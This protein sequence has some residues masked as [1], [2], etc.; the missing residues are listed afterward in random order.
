MS[1]ADNNRDIVELFIKLRTSTDPVVEKLR[2]GL[3]DSLPQEIKTK[4]AAIAQKQL[5]QIDEIPT[6]ILIERQEEQEYRKGLAIKKDLA[7]LRTRKKK[8][9]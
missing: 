8:S 3:M 5:D 4:S 6:D 9:L 7:R 2:E 1:E